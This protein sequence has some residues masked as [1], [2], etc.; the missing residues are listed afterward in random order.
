MFSWIIEKKAKILDINNGRITVENNFG[1]NLNIWQSIAHDWACMTIEKFD[2]KS[3]TFF[4]MQETF[5][6]TNFSVKKVGDYFN[7]ERC[8]RVWDRLDWHFVSWHI[9]CTWKVIKIDLQ[10]DSSLIIWIKFNENFS[11]LVI[12]KWSITINWVSLTVI[13]NTENSLEVS[14]IPL[15][16]DITNLWLL[17]I[18]DLVNLEFDMLGKYILN[19]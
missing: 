1:S 8:L 7:T 4:A 11:K 6:R 2:D 16:L 10:K 14:L 9:D 5:N 13:K 19:K 12:G 3:Y 15:T 18:W 17:K